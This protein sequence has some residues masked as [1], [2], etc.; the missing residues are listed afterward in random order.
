MNRLLRF[1]VLAF[2]TIQFSAC[3]FE[4]ISR[5]IYEGVRVHSESLKSTPM[6]KSKGE[7]MSYE[8]YERERQGSVS[9]KASE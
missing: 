7:S 4:H 1:V 3:A 8:Q 5:N 6:E 2:F 9:G